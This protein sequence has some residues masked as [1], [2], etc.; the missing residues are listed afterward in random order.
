MHHKKVLRGKDHQRPRAADSEKHIPILC[1]KDGFNFDKDGGNFLG[2]S[3]AIK[4]KN[5]RKA[6]GSL[7]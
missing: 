7:N 3:W 1:E 4:F 2:G 6:Q 5:D